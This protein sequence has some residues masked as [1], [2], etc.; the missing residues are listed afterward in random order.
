MFLFKGMTG[1]VK[2]IWKAHTDY[3]KSI[4]SL[5]G[6]RKFVRDLTINQTGTQPMNKSLVFLF[7]IKGK[8]TFSSLNIQN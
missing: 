4:K 6:K 8:K 1:N 2:A 3:Y 7:Y 5:K